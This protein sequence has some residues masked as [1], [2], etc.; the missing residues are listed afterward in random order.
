[1]NYEIDLPVFTANIEL[2]VLSLTGQQL[3]K[4]K[5]TDKMGIIDLQTGQGTYILN[6]TMN[7]KSMYSTRII[8]AK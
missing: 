1:L 8:I 6:C 3:L 4:K 2:E 7:G 5:I